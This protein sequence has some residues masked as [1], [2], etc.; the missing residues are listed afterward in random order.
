MIEI[1]K[2]VKTKQNFL[3][4]YRAFK[5]TANGWRAELVAAWQPRFFH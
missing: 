3:I 2:E 1:V 4:E 5:I